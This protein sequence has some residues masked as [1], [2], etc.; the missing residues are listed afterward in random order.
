MIDVDDYNELIK[1][2]LPSR[3]FSIVVSVILLSLIIFCIIRMILDFKKK[4]NPIQAKYG[5]RL[6]D[7]TVVKSQSAANHLRLKSVEEYAGK[8]PDFD[9]VQFIELAKK[10]FLRMI[11]ILNDT[12]TDPEKIRYCFSDQYYRQLC[13][14]RD[15]Y[16]LNGITQNIENVE[17]FSVL[18]IGWNDE[19]GSDTMYV[20]FKYTC[21][22]S[23]LNKQT[24]KE[25]SNEQSKRL[26]IETELSF[27][28][29]D[30][31]AAGVKELIC[32]NCG[33]VVRVGKT[34]KCGYCDTILN[35]D[36]YDW[37]LAGDNEISVT[38]LGGNG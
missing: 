31:S 29:S 7:P 1:Q 24:G 8:Y 5:K 2:I 6:F 23:Y 32:P 12:K 16:L 14:V 15:N 9:S 11:T 3:I 18:P 34:G 37:V 27:Q 20:R 36:T 28:H 26:R 33:G 35:A 13:S 25:I 10:D 19:D 17:F 38:L 4:K 30:K 21:F 22:R